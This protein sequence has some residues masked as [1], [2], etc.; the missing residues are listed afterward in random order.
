MREFESRIG[1]L[2]RELTDKQNEIERVETEK[3]KIEEIIDPKMDLDIDLRDQTQ[4][5]NLLSDRYRRALKQKVQVY[6]ELTKAVKILAQRNHDYM[7]NK[8]DLCRQGN[9]VNI[10][11]LVSQ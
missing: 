10:E 11:K 9:L 6:D 7:E 5:I 8:I 3:R 2:D 4:E 1:A